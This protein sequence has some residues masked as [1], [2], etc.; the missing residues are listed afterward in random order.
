MIQ[1]IGSKLSEKYSGPSVVITDYVEY[2]IQ[3]LELPGYRV[4]YC[5]SGGILVPRSSI[6]TIHVASMKLTNNDGSYISFLLL[7]V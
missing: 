3:M 1:L 5:V 7:W 6:P 4:S 2:R